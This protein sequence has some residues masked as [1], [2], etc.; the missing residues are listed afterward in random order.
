[1][2]KSPPVLAQQLNSSSI[3]NLT[4]TLA[5]NTSEDEEETG[6]I[7][8]AN[9]ISTA[10]QIKVSNKS[11]HAGTVPSRECGVNRRNLS[12]N[13]DQSMSSIKSGLK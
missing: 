6:Y 4:H 11:T 8:Q 12:S 5:F 3:Q 2:N 7:K 9:Y 10:S 1:M 13:F